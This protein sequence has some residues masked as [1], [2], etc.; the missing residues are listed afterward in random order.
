MATQA[1]TAGVEAELIRRRLM[2]APDL[3]ESLVS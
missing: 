1:I 3:H 2:L